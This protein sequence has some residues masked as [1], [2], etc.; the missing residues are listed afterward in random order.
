MIKVGLTG[1]IGSGKS[2][3]ATIFQ[4]LGVPVYHADLE[5]RK[6]LDSDPVKAR[7]KSDFGLEILDSDYKVDRRVLASKVFVSQERLQQLNAIIHPLVL[8][9]FNQWCIQ[10][11]EQP[12]IL[13]E[14]AIIFE[15]GF[16]KH[17]SNMILV[18]APL[19]AC[20]RRVMKRDGVDADQVR[21]RMNNQWELGLKESKADFIIVNDGAM[22]LLPQVLEIHHALL[23]IAG[24]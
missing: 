18:S 20:I 14:A 13:H 9:D 2:L 4:G 5:A 24:F 19:E 7:L 15:T 6:F 12:Y 16:D 11:S 1:G 8:N 21:L 17:F 3:V 23:E 10:R 22:M